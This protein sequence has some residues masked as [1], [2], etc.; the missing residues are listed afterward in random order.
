MIRT[1]GLNV[2]SRMLEFSP[3]Q[4]GD[5]G[6]YFYNVSSGESEISSTRVTLRGKK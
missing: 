2:D 1:D 6:I 4:F 5:E 3:V